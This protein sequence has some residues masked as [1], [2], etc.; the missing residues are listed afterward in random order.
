MENAPL[1]RS[2]RRSRN[3][4]EHWKPTPGRIV[5]IAIVRLY[6]LTLSG[7]IGN[8]CRHLP[9]CSE[10][11]YEAIARHGLWIG[12]WLAL[13]RIA[14]CGPGGT[15]GLDPVPADI[16]PGAGWKPWSLWRHGRKRGDD[17]A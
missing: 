13:F 11:G 2:R 8:A 14:R 5:G 17:V 9:T 7:F 4:S 1:A 12:G 6:Q 16:G 10:Y 3:W 15:C